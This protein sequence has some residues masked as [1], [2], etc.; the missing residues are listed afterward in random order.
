MSGR[1]A[2]NDHVMN[3]SKYSLYTVHLKQILFH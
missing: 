1:Q 3:R 2:T